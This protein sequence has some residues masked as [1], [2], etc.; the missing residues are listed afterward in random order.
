[1]AVTEASS[2]SPLYVGNGV[3]TNF[4]FNFRV[5]DDDDLLVIMLNT[6]T[7]VESTLVKNVDYTVAL[8]NLGVSGGTITVTPAPSATKKLRIL[9]K[10]PKDQQV[11]ILNQGS[12]FPSILVGVFDKL[13]LLVQELSDKIDRAMKV[14]VTSAESPEELIQEMRDAIVVA[15]GA[16]TKSDAAV[17]T[18]NAANG[19]SN[20]AL[21]NSVTAVNTANAAVATANSAVNTAN[22]AAFTAAQADAKGD[23]AIALAQSLFNAAKS[24]ADVAIAAAISSF[25][26]YGTPLTWSTTMTGTITQLSTPFRFDKGILIV[27][28]VTYD[29]A[30]P[31][32][33]TL[34]NVGNTIIQFVTPITGDHDIVL[35]AF[36]SGS[37]AGTIGTTWGTTLDAG[38]DEITTPYLFTKGILYVG[39]VVF[40]LSDAAHATLTEVG[41]VTKITLG[42]TFSGDQECILVILG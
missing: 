10:T 32:Q 4:A 41:G 31:T 20:T 38:E 33:V 36:A 14:D 27:G 39:G 18:A 5:L 21:A 28:G 9:R 26:P 23:N 11:S 29:L 6:V 12:F 40:N 13:V 15:E 30:D 42:E 3:L 24:Y 22:A 17:A 8:V 34:L 1:M 37:A 2:V 7:G 35:L 16:N 19:K 25:L